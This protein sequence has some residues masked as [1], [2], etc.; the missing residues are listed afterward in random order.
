M[1]QHS[2]DALID[3]T[4]WG[5]YPDYHDFRELSTLPD[6]YWD[7]EAHSDWNSWGASAWDAPSYGYWYQFGWGWSFTNIFDW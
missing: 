3:F 5:M 1:A 4:G 6:Y 7:L 2:D